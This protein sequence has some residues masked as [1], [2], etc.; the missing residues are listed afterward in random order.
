M[1]DKGLLHAG[2]IVNPNLEAHPIPSTNLA[3]VGVVFH[4]G[5]ASLDIGCVEPTILKVVV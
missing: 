5:I 1:S 3:G 2:A 4:V